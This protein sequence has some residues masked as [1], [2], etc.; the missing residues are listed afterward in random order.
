MV[1]RKRRIVIIIISVA[2]GTI[3]SG[4]IMQQRFGTLKPENIKQLTYNFIFALLIVIGIGVLL[5]KMAS[6]KKND[7]GNKSDST[8]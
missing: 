7:P 4:Y 1:S 5:A 6:S 8:G 3:L 2:L